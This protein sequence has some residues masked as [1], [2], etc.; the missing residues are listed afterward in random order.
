MRDEF[1]SAISRLL[2]EQVTPELLRECEL[3]AAEKR[4]PAALW[5][6]VQASGFHLAAAPEAQGGAGASWAD[7]FAVVRAAGRFNLPLPL[8]E[9]LLANALLGHCGLAAI[10][11]PISLAGAGELRLADG[12]VSGVLFDV[13][14]G[15][16]VPQVVAV[17]SGVAGVAGAAGARPCLVLLN[18]RSAQCEPK[19]NVAGEP[20][21]DLRFD[22]VT[23]L[24]VAPLP[25][26]TPADVLLLGGAMLRGAQIAGAMQAVLEQ[27]TRYATER[28]QFGK[29]IGNFQSIQHAIAVLAEHC[30]AASVAAECAFAEFA[31]ADTTDA[32]AG[33]TAL[34]TATL[35]I[36]AA[37]ICS[38]EAASVAAQ[39]AHAVHGAIGF[40][41]EHALQQ[42]TR[43]LWSWRSEFGNLTHWSQRLGQAVCAGGSAA[44]WPSLTAG[45]IALP[46]S[47]QQSS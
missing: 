43:R 35:P 9:A 4:W 36:A 37:K 23:P 8:P 30:G 6:A 31:L 16:E 22:G 33:R 29:P 45:Q 7:L 27:T 3:G 32:N 41:H 26:G 40:T 15:R 12:R 28:V 38:A 19:L 21:D 42:S 2:A 20:R 46:A 25:A 39:V 10:D 5:A 34:A 17:V 24:A 18:A 13:P 11:A 44:L 47:Q 14:W 1:E